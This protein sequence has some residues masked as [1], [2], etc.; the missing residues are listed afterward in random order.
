MNFSLT[1]FNLKLFQRSTSDGKT[2]KYEYDTAGRLIREGDRTYSYGYLDKILS[3]Q[4]NGQKI[5]SFDYHVDGQAA[6]AIHD[7]EIR[8]N[9][10]SGTDL[11]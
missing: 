3:V 6:S 7:M 4:G 10:S 2:T 8:L 9:P 1:T 11:L 5:A